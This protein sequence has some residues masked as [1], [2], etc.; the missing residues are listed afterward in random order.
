M[1]KQIVLVFLG[2][3]TT[4]NDK[5]IRIT[6]NLLLNFNHLSSFFPQCVYIVSF[7]F[8]ILFLEFY[9]KPLH[10]TSG[11]LKDLNLPTHENISI[12]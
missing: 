10:M 9:L 3:N 1:T 12:S 8:E 6:A 5:A 2:V 7:F 11:S 4:K